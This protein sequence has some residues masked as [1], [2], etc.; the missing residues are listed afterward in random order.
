VSG[1]AV[2]RRRDGRRPLVLQVIPLVGA[3]QDVFFLARAAILLTDLDVERSAVLPDKALVTG[4]GLTS[5]EARLAK[6]LASGES[7]KEAA[8]GEGVT[9]ETAR[10]RLKV[11]FNK[12]NVHRQAE[13][14]RLLNAAAT[15]RS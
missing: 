8:D 7:L 11:I 6:R 12:L 3:A 10:S 1:L 15:L 4:F 14:V 9:F 13:L 5:S 2:V